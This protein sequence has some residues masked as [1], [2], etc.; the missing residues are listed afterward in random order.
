MSRNLKDALALLAL[1][2][3][4]FAVTHCGGAIDAPPLSD[5]DASD[6]EP[7]DAGCKPATVLLPRCE[8]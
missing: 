8:Q 1:A 5:D 3:A 2:L 4:F 7:D 6:V